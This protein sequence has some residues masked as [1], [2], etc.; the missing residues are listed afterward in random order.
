MYSYHYDP[1]QPRNA[2]GEWT[3]AGHAIRAAASDKKS[4]KR[5]N[6]LDELKENI[7]HMTELEKKMRIL[8]EDI[9]FKQNNGATTPEYIELITAQGNLR[10]KVEDLKNLRIGIES[11]ELKDSDIEWYKQR[12]D[13]ID[14][15]REH[16]NA[17][18]DRDLVKMEKE[19]KSAKRAEKKALQVYNSLK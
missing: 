3:D 14:A 18:L 11:Y 9:F 7:D 12:G 13:D 16:L 10:H 4:D 17:K 15:L 1:S 6:A 5:L 8:G 19:L 2:E